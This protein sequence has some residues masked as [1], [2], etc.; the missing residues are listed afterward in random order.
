M[1]KTQN[2]YDNNEFFSEYS[3][4][5]ENSINANELIEM[6]TI[7]SMLTDLKE[8][9]ILDLGCGMGDMA[10]YF[11][12]NGAKSVYAIDLSINMLNEAIK[13]NSLEGI[14]YNQMA[15][16]NID[17]IDRKFDI[18]YSSLT[19]HYIEDFNKLISDISNLLNRNGVLVFSQ[20]HP[21]TTAPI[22]K[23]KQNKYIEIN[24]KRYYLLSDYNNLSKR[25]SKVAGTKLLTKYHR[26]FSTIINTLISNNFTILEVKEPG[27]NKEIVRLVDKYK[28]QDD[29]PFFIFIK[30]KKEF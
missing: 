22:I 5:R 23:G 29:K 26:N 28:Y 14:T 1:K 13:K 24:N 25:K 6:P 15:L 30:A 4:M 17:Q 7:K 11:I 21:L 8:K 18:V 27:A 2:F 19:F 12:K 3:K 20:E 9:E 16:E 10:A